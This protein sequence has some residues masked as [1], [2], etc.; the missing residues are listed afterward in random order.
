MPSQAEKPCSTGLNVTWVS[1]FPLVWGIP[2]RT[3]WREKKMPGQSLRQRM[4][5][6]QR[7]QGQFPP[8]PGRSETI[9]VQPGK[10][11]RNMFAP[12]AITGR[13]TK[14]RPP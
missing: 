3:V 1:N 4:P 14:T 2:L 8:P 10:S 13:Q 12:A 11:G 7:S 5:R 9:Y 6:H